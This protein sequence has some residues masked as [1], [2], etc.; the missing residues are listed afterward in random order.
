MKTNLRIIQNK[1]CLLLVLFSLLI[2]ACEINTDD[3]GTSHSLAPEFRKISNQPF[4]FEL[5]LQEKKAVYRLPDGFTFSLKAAQNIGD[6]TFVIGGDYL[7]NVTGTQGICIFSFDRNGDII[8]NLVMDWYHALHMQFFHLDKTGFMIAG[9]AD[10]SA[11][12][13][14]IFI[15]KLDHE[16]NYIYRRGGV[17]THE[18]PITH[19]AYEHEKSLNCQLHLSNNQAFFDVDCTTGKVIY[20]NLPGDGS[21]QIDRYKDMPEFTLRSLTMRHLNQSVISS[22]EIQLASAH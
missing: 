8:D 10:Y 20:S 17:W 16:A 18:K 21:I 12:E 22:K 11:H 2:G 14:E 9:Y 1:H 15:V 6:S 7:Q 4:T 13:K 3:S 19:Y 5:K